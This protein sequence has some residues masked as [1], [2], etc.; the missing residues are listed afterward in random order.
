MIIVYLYDDNGYFKN[1]HKCQT[2]MQD[3]TLYPAGNYTEI[4]P[5]IEPN[6]IPKFE[7]GAWV[8]VVDYR[9]TIVYEKATRIKIIWNQI[10]EVTTEYTEI[11]PPGIFY[12][13][14]TSAWV[15]DIP[16]CKEAKVNEARN[17]SATRWIDSSKTVAA[18][19]AQYKVFK[20]GNYSTIAEVDTAY[21]NFISWME[22]E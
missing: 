6:K 19:Q 2:G 4:E 11:E 13:W 21:N 22:I 12:K 10:T 8:N 14:E 16:R 5:T 18:I 20:A 15:E 1:V 3:E 9:G 7:S 17:T